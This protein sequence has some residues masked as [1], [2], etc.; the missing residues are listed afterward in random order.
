M[1]EIDERDCQHG[2]A[3]TEQIEIEKLRNR[4][5]ELESEREELIKSA[6]QAIMKQ[7][8]LIEELA[9]LRQQQGEPV[10]W[11]MPRGEAI[12]SGERDF[13]R[14]GGVP[15]YR[16]AAPK[17]QGEPVA[18]VKE[19]PYDYGT[20][21]ES[22]GVVNLQPGTKLYREA[23][24]RVPEGWKLV[25]VEPTEEMIHAGVHVWGRGNVILCYRAML[26][27]APEWKEKE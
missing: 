25:P 18:V 1:R 19:D 24:P 11:L 4:I 20:V 3:D 10:A 16:E 22:T 2:L 9:A 26:A 21:I 8:M 15:L 27:D 17:Q 23:A 14:I 12:V 5:R 6:K 7:G 13:W